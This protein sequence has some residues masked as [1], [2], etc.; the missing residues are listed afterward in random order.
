M[1]MLVERETSAAFRERSVGMTVDPAGSAL[2]AGVEAE[3]GSSI[4]EAS[5]L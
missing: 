1:S 3:V 4:V 2:R 5:T